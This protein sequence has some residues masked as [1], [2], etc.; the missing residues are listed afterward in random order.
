VASEIRSYVV[1]IPALTPLATP[2]VQ[3]ITF[4]PRTVVQVDWQVPPGP[5]GLMG[6]SLTVGGQPV[7]PRNQ[8]GWIIADGRIQSWPLEGY[9]DQ[10][11]WQVSGYNADIYPH[12]VYLDFLLE[13]NDTTTPPP[14]QIPVEQLSSPT[15]TA[16]PAL[17]P[18]P[19]L[20][21]ASS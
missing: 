3:A 5:S 8:G 6:W 14:A 13:L 19:D 4:P 15:V 21:L 7:I 17:P 18:L 1:T 2:F 16:T 9:P 20:T 12:S 11:E 10:G